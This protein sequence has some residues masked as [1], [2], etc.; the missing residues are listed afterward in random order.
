MSISNIIT[1]KENFSRVG[2]KWLQE[3]DN[4]LIEECINKKNIEEIALEHKRTITGIKLR[5]IGKI[6]YPDYK[7]NNLNINDL[8]LKYNIEKELIIKHISKI[9]T[10]DISKIETNDINNNKIENIKD[11]NKVKKIN[12]E[13][14][15]IE[16]ITLLDNKIINIENKLDYILILLQKKYMF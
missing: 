5:I 15:L 2:K 12:K 3:E 6:I 11:I 13:T 8:S 9:E 1:N 4:I 16:K 14:L 7:N 10:N